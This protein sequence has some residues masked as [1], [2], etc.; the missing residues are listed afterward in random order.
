MLRNIWRI[1][2]FCFS[3]NISKVNNLTINKYQFLL[4]LWDWIKKMFFYSANRRQI[5]YVL[6][7]LFF[8]WAHSSLSCAH[9]FFSREHTIVSHE[10]VEVCV[11]LSF[12][13]LLHAHKKTFIFHST[14]SHVLMRK[15]TLLMH[16]VFA[17]YLMMN[18]TKP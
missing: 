12:A 9:Y 10:H 14:F 13:K 4:F 11:F 1:C 8:S 5:L 3:C 17:F 16:K 6:K 2:N 15:I 7:Q 18:E